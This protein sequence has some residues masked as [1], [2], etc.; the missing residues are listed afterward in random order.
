M[1]GVGGFAA[2]HRRIGIDTSVF[3]YH[4]EDVAEYRAAADAVLESVLRGTVAGVTSVLTLVELTVKPH[5]LGRWD[6][7]NQY[8]SVLLGWPN[9]ALLTIDLGTARRAT[10]LRARHRL[11]TV[12]AL[13][14]AA[15]LESGATGFVSNDRQLRSV[16]ELEVLLLSD[17]DQSLEQP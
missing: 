4:L 16:T 9:L 3:I 11:R 10:A 8:T 13:Q 1:A 17:M 14:I 7:V 2:R 12:D 15:A 6:I 5:S